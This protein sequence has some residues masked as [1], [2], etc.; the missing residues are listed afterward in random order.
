[1]YD[2]KDILYILTILECIEKVFIYTND[3]ETHEAFLWKNDQ[4][5]FN[6]CNNLLIAIREETKKI[7]SEFK[8]KTEEYNWREISGLRDRLAH[9]YRGV[10]PEIIFSVIKDYL[11]E[12]KSILLQFFEYHP[13]TK[14]EKELLKQSTYYKHINYLFD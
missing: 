7:S 1:M 3:I 2:N 11:H 5:N 14:T 12:F 10:N 9:D 6:A 8:A 4:M 13:L